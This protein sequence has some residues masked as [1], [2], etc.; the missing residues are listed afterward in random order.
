[1][2]AENERLNMKTIALGN[3]QFLLRFD[4]GADDLFYS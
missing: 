2:L 1:M 3:E 4:C